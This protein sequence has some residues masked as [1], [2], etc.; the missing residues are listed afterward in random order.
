M[1]RAHPLEKT[2]MLGKTENKR[3]RQSVRWLVGW[4]YQLIGHESEQTPRDSDVQGGLLQ[5]MGSQRVRH[6][7]TND[8]QCNS[9]KERL[10]H[11]VS[12]ET[13]VQRS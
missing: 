13:E 2:S 5:S 3:E 11:P 6:E 7:Q 12:K 4:H 8:E 9:M 1:R 10:P